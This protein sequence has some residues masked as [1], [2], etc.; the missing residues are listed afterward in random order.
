MADPEVTRNERA[1]R[2]EITVDGAPAGFAD[3]RR[4]GNDYALTHTEI[5]DALAGRGLGS[6]LVAGVLADLRERGAGLL[7]YCSFVRAYLDRHPEYVALVPPDRR[8]E[9]DLEPA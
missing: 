9:F 3:Y 8:A 5:D 4:H 1:G 6:R 2:Y 7:P